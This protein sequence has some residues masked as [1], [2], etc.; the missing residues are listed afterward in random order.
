MVLGLPR[1]DHHH[2]HAENDKDEEHQKNETAMSSNMRLIRFLF[3]H[4]LSPSG[5]VEERRG[6]PAW[7]RILDAIL[8]ASWKHCQP[9][10]PQ[11]YTLKKR[12]TQNPLRP[13]FSARPSHFNGGL[14]MSENVLKGK[15]VLIV[16]DER[17]VLETLED[18]LDMC[19]VVKA[20][21]FEEAKLALETQAFDIAVLDIMGVDGYKLLDIA[22]NRKVIPVML[23]AHALSPDHTISSY[24]R[25][26][27]LYVPKDKIANIADYLNDVLE[28]IRAGK[29]TWWRWLDKFESYYNKKF[30]AKW[31]NKDK[32]FWRSFPSI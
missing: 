22:K 5:F 27:A 30:E 20:S 19:E 4:F 26:A 25:G 18:L 1:I 6:F 8:R 9:E 2:H 23:T 17:D 12:L 10:I 3:L 7:A 13:S 21:T 16:D 24:K 29:S 15:T 31:K 14:K 32:D 28:A 11:G